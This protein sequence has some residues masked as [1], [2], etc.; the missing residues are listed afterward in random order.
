MKKI[1]LCS[2][3]GLMLQGVMPLEG[4]VG[5]AAAATASAVQK[6]PVLTATQIAMNGNPANWKTPFQALNSAQAEIIY[7]PFSCANGLTELSITLTSWSTSADSIF[8]YFDKNSLSTLKPV[9]AAG[10]YIL[11]NLLTYNSVNYVQVQ[12]TDMNNKVYAHGIYPLPGVAPQYASIGFNT[13]QTF[14]VLP[15]IDPSKGQTFINWINLSPGCRVLYQQMSGVTTKGQGSI[16]LTPSSLS[17][18]PLILATS[19]IRYSTKQCN[20]GGTFPTP[21]LPAT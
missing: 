19:K 4:S 2:V 7:P 15:Q 14:G 6:M 12:L 20:F 3:F 17:S 21:A 5:S 1:L 8:F 16:G 18:L 10:M 9:M 11:V 13:S